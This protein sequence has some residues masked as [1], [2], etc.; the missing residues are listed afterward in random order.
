MRVTRFRMDDAWKPEHFSEAG[1]SVRLASID[2]E[3]PLAE[4]Y[5]EVPGFGGK[6]GAA[7]G[8]AAE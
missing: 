3:M 2:F 7:A 5:D 8:S 1:A 4:I 6:S